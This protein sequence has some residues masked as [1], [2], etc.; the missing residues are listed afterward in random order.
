MLFQRQIQRVLRQQRF[1]VS[2]C[3]AR[4][5][6]LL[7]TFERRLCVFHHKAGLAQAIPQ[8][9]AVQRLAQLQGLVVAEVFV[10]GGVFAE[11]GLL[12]EV[13]VV[14]VAPHAG[15]EVG[16][17]LRTRLR[18]ALS[19]CIARRTRGADARVLLLRGLVG[20]QQIKAPSRCASTRQSGCEHRGAQQAR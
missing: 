9:L 11:E 17:Q 1:H 13:H 5:Q 20:L 10:V 6:F 3:D 14:F 19:S 12:R 2:T 8:R 7:F 15:R 4:G 18:Q 16:Q